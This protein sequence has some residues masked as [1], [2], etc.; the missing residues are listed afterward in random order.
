MKN[1]CAN[2]IRWKRNLFS[3]REL[4]DFFKI[5]E[6]SHA[7][8]ST[9]YPMCIYIWNIQAFSIRERERIGGVKIFFFS[10]KWK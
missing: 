7:T 5:L 4:S 6:V 10:G 1:E 3:P 8:N 9:K 2:A